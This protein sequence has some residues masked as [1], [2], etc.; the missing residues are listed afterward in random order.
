VRRV[1][2]YALRVALGLLVCVSTMVAQ[3]ELPRFV[4]VG[5]LGAAE[6]RWIAET[7]LRAQEAAALTGVIGLL[8]GWALVAQATL[9]AVAMD[10]V[11][12][13]VFTHA[14][15]DGAPGF[16]WLGV[17]LNLSIGAALALSS[18]PTRAAR[19]ALLPVSRSASPRSASSS[20]RS[21]PSSCGP[22]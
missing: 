2:S 12:L 20:N 7:W 21:R 17:G 4:A 9:V 13:A 15:V 11:F 22:R 5:A 8:V 16:P 14:Y 3:T 19:N 10:T 18:P 1:G 6:V